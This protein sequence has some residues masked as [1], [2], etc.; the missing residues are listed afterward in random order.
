MK[1]SMRH[2]GPLG[3]LSIL[4]AAAALTLALS[5]AG[6]VEAQGRPADEL[7]LAVSTRITTL[8]PTQTL[9]ISS[10]MSAIGHLYSALVRRTADLK[11]VPDAAASWEL[12]DGTTWRFRLVPGLKFPN[13]EPL[14]AEAVRWNIEHVLAEATKARL[15]ALVNPVV[16]GV[17]AVDAATVEIRTKEP[18]L[19]LLQLLAH[20]FLLP[21]KWAG[22]PGRDLSQQAMGTGPY[23]LKEFT[24]GDRIVLEAKAGYFGKPP[25]FRRI[26]MLTKTEASSRVAALLAGE[27]DYVRD[28]PF[29][30][31]D[32]INK[33]RAGTASLVPSTRTLMIHL[34]TLVPPFKDNTLLR[35]ALNHAVNKEEITK[36]LYEGRVTPS[37][38]QIVPPNNFGFQ[39][40]L[41]PIEYNP[42]KAK[43][44]LAQAGYPRG[45]SMTMEVP[46]GRYLQAEEIS[47]IIASQLEAVGVQVKIAEVDFARWLPRY[48]N[49][50]LDMSAYTGLTSL[51]MDAD[52]ILTAAST[53]PYGYWDN[54]K[55]AELITK[56]RS[57]AT[58]AQRMAFY[59]EASELLCAEAPF[60]FLFEQ[61]LIYATS[62]SIAWQARGDEWVNGDDFSTR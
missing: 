19:P 35:Q 9:V 61:P 38:C 36:A 47:Q 46:T 1:K 42:A 49:R 62:R 28:I 60:I 32:R 8:N 22:E 33:S 29:T 39:P 4:A 56:A 37:A 34:N 52:F 51:T 43:Q 54:P 13:G 50:Q 31:M 12:V 3:R 14:D 58:E 44:L 6:R 25:V 27:V 57:Q 2:N 53:G 45:L 55:F 17:T 59:K 11:I 20:V 10:D 30:E 41:K 48:V 24:G 18:Y 7:R 40:H 15:R 23:D 26:V 16:A 21:P 5:V